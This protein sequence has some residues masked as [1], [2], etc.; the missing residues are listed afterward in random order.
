MLEQYF[1][2][3]ET[4]IRNQ[5]PPQPS[6]ADLLADDIMKMV[7][8]NSPESLSADDDFDHKR[9]TMTSQIQWPGRL[10]A[11]SVTMPVF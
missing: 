5:Q 2:G 11:R 7:V 4:T 6:E 10:A 8:P 1:R 9:D 3:V